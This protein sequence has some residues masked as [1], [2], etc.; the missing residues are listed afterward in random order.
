M[1]HR[2]LV[3]FEPRYL[4]LMQRCMEASCD[5]GVCSGPTATVG[6]I[7][8]IVSC[9]RLPYGRLQ[10]SCTVL[11][12]F[13]IMEPPVVEDNTMGTTNVRERMLLANLIT[14]LGYDTTCLPQG[15]ILDTYACLPTKC[16]PC[17]M[18]K[19][20]MTARLYPLLLLLAPFPQSPS[21]PRNHRSRPSSQ[22]NSLLTHRRLSLLWLRR[23]PRARPLG[24]AA[25]SH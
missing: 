17:P 18:K 3:V 16:L 11:T 21:I 6:S 13:A 14:C 8:N 19:S 2:E 20:M 24:G 12:R 4:I 25:T 5:F 10:V 22:G 15:Y 7:V 1:C 9:R 23:L